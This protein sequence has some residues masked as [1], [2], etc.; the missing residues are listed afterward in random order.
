MSF[1]SQPFAEPAGF[2]AAYVEQ[3]TRAAASVRPAAIAAAAALMAATM[4]RDGQIF[5]CGNGGSAAIA[6]HLVC[7]CVKSVQ[8]DTR[9]TPRVHSLSA[10]VSF[11]TAV[12]NDISYDEVFA[13]QL[14]SYAR[15]GDLLLTISSSGNSENIV[16]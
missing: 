3:L 10:N 1:P 14:K 9:L 2:Y 13:Y 8:T 6:N 15:P 4:T 5:V 12:A 16:R 7:D 11:M